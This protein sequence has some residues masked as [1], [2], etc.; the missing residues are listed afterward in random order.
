MLYRHI[1]NMIYVLVVHVIHVV[2]IRKRWSKE[3][4]DIESNLV[5]RMLFWTNVH[6]Q[7]IGKSASKQKGLK[8]DNQMSSRPTRGEAE[9]Y[10]IS[11]YERRS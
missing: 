11:A 5:H 6:N 4:V 3:S 1:I 10:V 7:K 2:K 8:Q 9:F